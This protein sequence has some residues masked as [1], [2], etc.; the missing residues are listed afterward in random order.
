MPSFRTEGRLRP[1]RPRAKLSHIAAGFPRLTAF[2]LSPTSQCG[3]SERV[4]YSSGR[5]LPAAMEEGARS[6]PL[7]TAHAAR[8]VIS[9]RRDV[10]ASATTECFNCCSLCYRR[11]A[12]WAPRAS[13]T[14]APGRPLRGENAGMIFT[15]RTILRAWNRVQRWIDRIISRFHN[16]TRINGLD[17]CRDRKCHGLRSMEVLMDTPAWHRRRHPT[18]RRPPAW[19]RCGRCRWRSHAHPGAHLLWDDAQRQISGVPC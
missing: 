1:L 17:R 5:S 11:E 19:N 18:P 16:G 14:V 7:P 2:P 6:A 8:C 15:S 4:V 10:V 9:A 13:F 12:R 3:R